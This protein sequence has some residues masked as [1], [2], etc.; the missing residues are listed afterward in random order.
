MSDIPPFRRRRA[1]IRPLLPP[2][3]QT[4]SSEDG[5]TLVEVV[6]SALLVGF[7]AIAIF[8][9]FNNINRTTAD[10][11]LHDQAAVLAAQ[12][13]EQLRSD[14]SEALDALEAAPHS[15]TQIVGNQKFT[16]TQYGKWFNDSNQTAGC[17]ATSKEANTNKNGSY[18]K[19]TSAVTWSQ[20]EA[21]TKRPVVSQTSFITPPDGSGLEVDVTNGGTPLQAVGGVTAIANGVSLTTPESGC[22]TFGAIPST[23]ASVEVKKLGDVM[24]NGAWRKVTEEL[25]IVPNLTTHYPVTLAPGGSIEGHFTYQGKTTYSGKEVTGDTFVE[26]NNNIKENPDYELGST[27]FEYEKSGEKAGNFRA[28]TG[29]F[30]TT[31]ASFSTPEYYP[32][33]DLFPFTSAWGVYAGDC[34]GNEPSKF[35]STGASV[36]VKGGETVSANIPMSYVKLEAYKGTKASKE[37][38]ET[39]AREVK[40]TNLSCSSAIAPNNSKSTLV[41][42]HLQKTNSEGA[43]TSPFQ[44]FGK[45]KLCLYNSSTSKTYTTEYTNEGSAQ[46][47]LKF[48]L[49]ESTGTSEGV[50]IKSAG[51]NTC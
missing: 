3:A 14:S 31:A 43:L 49:K 15:Y 39:T 35:G 9:G 48:Y 21:N 30:A 12:S 4:L 42:E 17:S 1:A 32:T 23:T 36:L 37:S 2:N 13:Q 19:I 16:I 11:R 40:I 29:N 8:S 24:E 6:V 38:L 50:T 28:L 45:F 7:I 41:T 44:P 34:L 47:T 22:V 51:S 46:T 10:Q 26:G 5:I 27:K 33:G 25:A 20:L 18:F